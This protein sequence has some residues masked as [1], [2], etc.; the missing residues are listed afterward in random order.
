MGLL[1]K[2]RAKAWVYDAEMPLDKIC[3]LF[4]ISLQ[5]NRAISTIGFVTA[6]AGVFS[7]LG[8]FPKRQRAKYY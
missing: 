1:F 5:A 2:K 8:L 4:L 3:F 7:F 6:V